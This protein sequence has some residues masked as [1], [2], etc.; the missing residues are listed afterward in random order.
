M[1]ARSELDEMC[2]ETRNEFALAVKTTSNSMGRVG[3]SFARRHPALLLGGGALLGF[4]AVQLLPRG[5]KKR[6][7]A[8]LAREGAREVDGHEHVAA[9]PEAQ[10]RKAEGPSKSV[11]FATGAAV[12]ILKSAARMWLLEHLSSPA[13]TEREPDV[14]DSSDLE[15]AAESVA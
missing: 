11:H 5:K 9:S 8:E 10:S 13:Q 7:P 12:R 6:S 14:V 3:L 2:R 1:T 4:A 15:A